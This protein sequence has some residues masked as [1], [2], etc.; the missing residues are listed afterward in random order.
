MSPTFPFF[1]SF[2]TKL[3]SRLPA[4]FD[5]QGE[6]A[7]LNVLYP[8]VLRNY[9]P[10]KAILPACCDLLLR[11]KSRSHRLTFPISGSI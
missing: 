6:S 10:A 11:Q 4:A 9:S 1:F 7:R 2:T 8:I 3:R 5:S